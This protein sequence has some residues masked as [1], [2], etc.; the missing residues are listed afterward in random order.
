MIILRAMENRK[1]RGI[2]LCPA[3]REGDTHVGVL[4]V[5]GRISRVYARPTAGFPR[6]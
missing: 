6:C 2:C 1:I 3:I 4:R 5:S